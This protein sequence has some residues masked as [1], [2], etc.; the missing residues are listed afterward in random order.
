MVTCLQAPPED[1]A[2]LQYLNPTQESAMI[3][4]DSPA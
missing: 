3:L 2:P 1:S 4:I